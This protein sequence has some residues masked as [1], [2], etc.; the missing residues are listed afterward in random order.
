MIPELSTDECPV[1]LITPDIRSVVRTIENHRYIKEFSG[2]TLFGSDLSMWPAW[3]AD[4][5]QIIQEEICRETNV[6]SK[7]IRD[8]RNK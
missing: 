7:E 3:Y 5:V 4:A 1:S 6:T 8:G 2:A